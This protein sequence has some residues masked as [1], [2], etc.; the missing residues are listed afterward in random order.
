[1][2]EN[3]STFFTDLTSDLTEWWT[4]LDDDFDALLENIGSMLDWFNPTSDKF[5]L[6]VAFVPDKEFMADYTSDF[7]GLLKTKLGFFFQIKDTM[8]AMAT[9]VKSEVSTWQGIQIDLSKWG[10]GKVDIVSGYAIQQ[11]GEKM[12]F[13]IGGLMIFLTGAWLVRKGSKL[14]GEGR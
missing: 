13:W 6:R 10:A 4:G 8:T 12:R 7:E 3:I 1:M 5:F 14:L 2:G 9:A 11:Y